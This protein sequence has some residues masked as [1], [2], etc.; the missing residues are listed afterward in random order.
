MRVSAIRVVSLPDGCELRARVDGDAAADE[1][2]WFAPFDLWW[3]FPTWCRDLL[4]PDNGD[5]FVAAL[6]VPAM[7]LG[8]P[9]AVPAPISPALRRALPDIESIFHC[10]DRRQTPIEVVAPAATAPAATTDPPAVGLFF[11][12]GVD[13]YYSLLKNMR[14]HPSDDA[15][16]THLIAVH[17][18]DVCH[19][20]WD[21]SFPPSILRDARRAADTLGKTLVPVATNLRRVVDPLALWTMSHGGALVGIAL[22]LGGLLRVVRVAATTTYDQLYPWG[23]HP[24][25]DHRWS[26]E[27]L[28]VIHDGCELDR[29]EKTRLVA[30]SPLALET[31]RV[32]PGYATEGNCGR[33]VKCLPTMIDLLQLGVLGR[34]PTLP[35]TIDAERLRRMLRDY[36]GH[37]NDDNYRRRLDAFPAG[38]PH[39]A[40][41]AALAEHLAAV[42]QPGSAQPAAK[43]SRRGPL[44]RWLHRRNG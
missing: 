37:L 15:T 6:L 21:E 1:A 19:G 12:L 41:R 13:S 32:C 22:A 10:F 23:S 4:D 33:C 35:Q 11:S 17:G 39:E 25:L 3:R 9:L 18:F 2:G 31:L 8:E 20:A 44:A 40:V 30:Q 26:T 14:D 38:G 5:P 27:R 34:C 36:R 7:T 43:G 29:I 42:E 28:T 16:V 24:V